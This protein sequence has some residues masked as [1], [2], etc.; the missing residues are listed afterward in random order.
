MK[1]AMQ[2]KLMVAA[3][4]IAA[5]GLTGCATKIQY[6]DATGV[7]TVTTDFG[8]TD[9]QLIAEK[10]V[11]DLLASPAMADIAPNGERPILFVESIKN[12]TTE[13]IDTESI[14]DTISTKL[15]NSRRF[16]FVDM[17]R[18]EDVQK[19]LNYQK[20]S[21]LVDETKA[22]QMG[23]QLGAK[24]M[25]YG[26]LASI[27]KAAGSTKDIYYKFTLKLSNIES[28]IVEFQ[29]EKEIRKTSKKSLFGG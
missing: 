5:L 11:D 13:H 3:L 23:K 8:S 24:F 15:L 12:K 7:E 1:N 21:G 6:G 17:S 4:A 26:N 22:A 27:T 18:M 20:N 28:G 9:L 29:S 2:N 25:L 16:R 19:Q 10:M 14:T